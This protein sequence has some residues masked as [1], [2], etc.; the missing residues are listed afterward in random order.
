MPKVKL[1]VSRVGSGFA[2]SAGEVV[3][4]EQ[5]EAARMIAAGQAVPVS[6]ERPRTAVRKPA[7]RAV[8]DRA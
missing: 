4:V 8:K 3:E 2:Q 5:A 1:T 6:E 7:E